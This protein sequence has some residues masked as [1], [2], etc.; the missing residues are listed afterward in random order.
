[1]THKTKYEVIAVVHTERNGG[2][3]TKQLELLYKG[4]GTKWD[5]TSASHKFLVPKD[6]KAYPGDTVEVSLEIQ[7]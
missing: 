2:H 7:K 5:E 1:M 4:D 6:F 3:V